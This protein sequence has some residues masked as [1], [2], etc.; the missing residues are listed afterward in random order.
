MIGNQFINPNGV[1]YHPR[2]PADFGNKPADGACR[3][4]E[5]GTVAET[6]QASR[7][8]LSAF[9]PEPRRQQMRAALTAGDVFPPCVRY[10]RAQALAGDNG[11][12]WALAETDPLGAEREVAEPR[13]WLLRVGW[14]RHGR[15]GLA[16]VPG[17]GS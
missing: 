8:V 17:T 3:V 16:E 4:A 12:P 1:V 15:I 9:T 5:M 11:R 10:L 7:Q 14:L 2:L 6:R 13:S